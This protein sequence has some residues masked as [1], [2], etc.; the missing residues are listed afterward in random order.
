MSKETLNWL[1]TQT[2]IGFT[3]KRGNAWHYRQ[4]SDNHYPGPVPVEDVRRRLFDWTA[5]E[6]PLYVPSTVPDFADLD[7]PTGYA[8]IPGRKAIV[9]SDNGDV[10]GIFRDGYQPHQYGEWLLTNVANLLDDDLG[11]GSAG[12]L[13][14]G[15]IAWVSVEVPDNIVTPSGVEFRPN[16]MATTS[17]DGSVSTTYKRHITNVVCDNTMNRALGEDGGQF[18]V[19]HSSKSLGRLQDARDALQIVHT[20]SADFAKE[21]ENLT[22]TEFGDSQFGQLVE[23]L[24]PMPKPKVAGGKPDARSKA[25]AENKRAVL[26]SMWTSDERVAPWRG[27]AWGAW[28]AANT[29]TQHDG[30][31]PRKGAHKAER[32]MLRVVRGDLADFD[33]MVVGKI[34]E[35]SGA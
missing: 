31:K 21:V 15:A 17:F 3:D 1:N 34:L 12:L 35:L 27:S 11:I 26:W 33:H 16:L 8:S 32:N 18:K 5:E 25:M 10:L 6:Q 9:R 7:A 22:A 24:A 19:R 2:L 4:G 23:T 20:M 29:F 14:G 13:K 30:N 28:Q